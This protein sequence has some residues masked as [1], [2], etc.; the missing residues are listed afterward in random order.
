MSGDALLQHCQA[1]RDDPEF[2]RWDTSE[3]I[4][5]SAIAAPPDLP[6]VAVLSQIDDAPPAEEA[7]AAVR[8]ALARGDRRLVG[9]LGP[10][11]SGQTSA[12]RRLA[13]QLAERPA[14]GAPIFVDLVRY[15]AQPA[16]GRRLCRTISEAAR[17][18]VSALADEVDDL[19][20][21]APPQGAPALADAQIVFILDGLDSVQ[22]QLRDDLARELLSLV[23]DPRLAAQR[24][25]LSCRRESLP[26]A[27]APRARLLLLQYLSGREV[28]RYLRARRGSPAQANTRFGQILD[29]QL[30]D[31]A[32]LPP[33]LANILS[34]LEDRHSGALTRNQLLQDNLD[35]QL[36]DLPAYLQRGD[37]ARQSLIALSWEMSWQP[38]EALDINRV[39]AILGEIRRER[40]YNLE[41][42]YEQLCAAGVL[43][44]VDRRQATFQRPGQRA[45]CAALALIQRESLPDALDDLLPQ[46]AVVERQDRW[47]PVLISLAG[48]VADYTPLMPISQAARATNNG[49]YM[50]LLAR[51]L[52]ALPRGM[53]E[54]L[55]P[56]ERGALL[57]ACAAWADPAREPSGVRRAQIADA[58]GCLPDAVSVRALLRLACERIRPAIARRLDYEYTSVRLSA[59]LGLRNLMLFRPPTKPA[60]VALW[61]NVAPPT[62]AALRAWVAAGD[63]DEASIR[64]IAQGPGTPIEARIIALFALADMAADGHDLLFLMRQIIAPP[65]PGRPD[66][67]EALIRTAADA[68]TLCDASKVAALIGHLLRRPPHLRDEAVAQ[69]IYIAGRVRASDPATL[70]WLAAQLMSHADPQIRATALRSLAWIVGGEPAL[71]LAGAPLAPALLAAARALGRAPLGELAPPPPLGPIPPLD[72][73][74]DDPGVVYLRRTA[75]ECLRWLPG[76]ADFAGLAAEAESWPIELRRALSRSAALRG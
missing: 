13:W 73:E 71:T 49:L 44:D 47:E 14:L 28:L 41:D 42:L 67:W 17:A 37:V 11:F 34:R 74:A 53:F 23:G 9:V 5:L 48:M 21:G 24:F 22:R 19:L 10:P 36:A 55:S 64:L 51:C 3:Y 43:H 66:D 70:A 45:Y 29:A 75:L 12:M 33:L 4:P 30:L 35:A 16:G 38:D 26:P 57:D 40:S 31:L 2:R 65:P 60:G 6:W 46:C 69:L 61:T 15:A 68:L 76:D 32:A 62:V 18:Y 20:A 58:L 63:G 54:Q 39:F 50:V 59:A 56:R 72:R 8:K 52:Q 1:L 25:V 27:I 7:V